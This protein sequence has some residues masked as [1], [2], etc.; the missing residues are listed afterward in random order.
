MVRFGL[1]PGRVMAWALPVIAVAVIAGVF[2]PSAVLWAVIVGV[3]AI[4]WLFPTVIDINGASTA[5]NIRRNRVTDKPYE[6]V[7]MREVDGTAVLLEGGDIVSVWMEVAPRDDVDVTTVSGD[8]IV[9][10]P[11]IDTAKL[12]KLLRQSDVVI[13]S[14]AVTTMS[15]DTFLPGYAA[16]NVVAQ[17]MGKIPV[18]S[19]GR[20]WITVRVRVTDNVSAAQARGA[21]EFDQGM[22]RA[23]LAAAAR[24]RVVVEEGGHHV[25]LCSPEMVTQ[26]TSMMAAGTARV[27]DK[28]GRDGFG[29]ETSDTKAYGLYPKRGVKRED[30]VGW[31]DLPGVR[32]FITTTLTPGNHDGTDPQVSD[33]VVLVTRD[34]QAV[35]RAS[36]MGLSLLRRQQRQ[37]AS[38]IIPSIASQP[39]I[40]PEYPLEDNHPVIHYGGG[41]GLFI[42]PTAQGGSLFI[43]VRP[44]TGT[45]LHFIG[46]VEAHQV[47]IERM[48]MESYSINIKLPADD[49]NRPVWQ[50]LVDNLHSPLLAMDSDRAADFVLTSP[51]GH[52]D[53]KADNPT[54]STIVVSEKTPNMALENSVHIKSTTAVV[55]TE[56]EQETAYFS[57]T[58]SEMGFVARSNEQ[59]R[60]R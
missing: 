6:P 54:Q 42:G 32:S 31:R 28:P 10:R 29:D 41:L 1:T 18:P 24:L 15:Y 3:F 23:V 56:T 17:S 7:R 39:V 43:K 52:A 58:P 22:I 46:A 53:A 45:T 37:A 30:A 47:L 2:V 12:A 14:I 51:Q 26:M 35:Q 25:S 27:F 5:E 4:V 38:R 60:T 16:G 8:G 11:H 33:Q 48:L 59:G 55:T 36:K 21:G 50:Q 34:K 20:S 57:P 49:P 13:E 44:A 9:S 19:G 40:Q